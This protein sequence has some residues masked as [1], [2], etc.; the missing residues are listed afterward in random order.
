[1]LKYMHEYR[2]GGML[3]ILIII[4]SILS[5]SILLLLF[6]RKDNRIEALKKEKQQYSVPVTHPSTPTDSAE[7]V[8]EMTFEDESRPIKASEIEYWRFRFSHINYSEYPPAYH[9]PKNDEK[10]N[11]KLN[12]FSKRLID[13]SLNI[14][15]DQK[16]TSLLNKDSANTKEISQLISADPILSAKIIRMA[17]S[18]YFNFSQ[19]V[20][21]VGRATVL[22]GF[23]HLK[24][25]I[26]Q[27]MM[28]SVSPNT[29]ESQKQQL[30]SLWHHSSIVSTCAGYLNVNL[31]G[32]VSMDIAT[33]GLLHDIGK[34]FLILLDKDYQ[35][36]DTEPDTVT[37]EKKYGINHAQLG[38][39][40]I[41]NW[42][43]PNSI[44]DAVYY[45]NYPTFAPI[46]SIPEHVRI[47]AA[48]L[49]I[50]NILSHVL[51]YKESAKDI[52]PMN[53]E[54]YQLLGISSDLSKLIT[55]KLL[56]EVE[57]GANLLESIQ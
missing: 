28:S 6:Q 39:Q 20:T 8:V 41:R 34:Y 42:Q 32:N 1:M 48:I 33:S 44:K 29:T 7:T 47:S 18:A 38:S 55:P 43:L 57:K 24:A 50:S 22:L 46:N 9:P 23:N 16:L 3:Y 31:L 5:I 27:H 25:L 30:T 49:N 11:A 52:F 54:Y 14:N 26:M 40:I 19:E 21:S 53:E 15:L 45:H 35:M 13:S 12:L 2:R 4:F 51:G 56:H 10:E 17:N 37:E 36:I